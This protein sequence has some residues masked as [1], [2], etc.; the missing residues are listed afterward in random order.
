MIK[1]ITQSIIHSFLCFDI[2]TH[3]LSLEKM[4]TIIINLCDE[5]S[6]WLHLLSSCCW[7]NEFTIVSCNSLSRQ[8][9]KWNLYFKY[10]R[11]QKPR[12]I[13]AMSHD[14]SSTHKAICI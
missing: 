2:F 1:D 9:K 13:L 12:A 6:I 4:S 7:L 11:T 10:N 8:I 14:F 3:N 5:K